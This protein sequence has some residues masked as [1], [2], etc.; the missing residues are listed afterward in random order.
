MQKERYEKEISE[1]K[2]KLCEI[3]HLGSTLALLNWDQEV[4][5]PRKAGASRAQ[6]I[7]YLS[8]VIHNKFLDLNKKSVLGTLKEAVDK[9][10]I[11]GNNAII[12]V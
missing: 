10:K 5:M 7:S 8:G 9:K 12:F 6:A 2:L 11:R 1:L 3:S 4:N